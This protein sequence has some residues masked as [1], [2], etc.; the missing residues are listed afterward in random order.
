MALLRVADVV[1][2][3]DNAGRRGSTL[4]GAVGGAINYVHYA[5]EKE[6]MTDSGMRKASVVS[7]GRKQSVAF[8]VKG[9]DGAH[10]VAPEQKGHPI[11]L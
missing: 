4:G 2:A 7:H 3:T 1:V 11:L 5:A 8:S 6:A 9:A 10:A